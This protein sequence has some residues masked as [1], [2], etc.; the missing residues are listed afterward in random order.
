MNDKIYRKIKE[1]QGRYE[2]SNYGDVRNIK[3]GRIMKQARTYG[4]CFVR[5]AKELGVTSQN[6]SNIL[7]GKTWR[8]SI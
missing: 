1:T 4:Y 8:E 5:L 6:I 2:I 3:T 7:L